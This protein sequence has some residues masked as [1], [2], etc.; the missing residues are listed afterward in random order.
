MFGTPRDG[1]KEYQSG[2]SAALIQAPLYIFHG[3]KIMRYHRD[4]SYEGRLVTRTMQT[5]IGVLSISSRNHRGFG[6]ERHATAP[7]NISRTPD[8]GSASSITAGRK[9]H[10][11]VREGAASLQMLAILRCSNAGFSNGYVQK[12]VVEMNPLF[13]SFNS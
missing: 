11:I 9:P 6:G 1:D 12:I 7:R 13:G 4:S 8:A 5:L 10:H 2:A 3:N